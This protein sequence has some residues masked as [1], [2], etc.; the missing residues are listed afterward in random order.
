MG[1]P[2]HL[3]LQSRIIFTPDTVQANVAKSEKG[4]RVGEE[5]GGKPLSVR[6][7]Y[8]G[9]LEKELGIDSQEASSL[10]ILFLNLS[11]LADAVNGHKWREAPC[12][13]GPYRR[14]PLMFSG[15]FTK[16]TKCTVE[17][18]GGPGQQPTGTSSPTEEGMNSP[19]FSFQS[20]PGGGLDGQ[21][22]LAIS[23]PPR[24]FFPLVRLCNS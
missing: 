22:T 19:V 1:S 20:W 12:Q 15:E 5:K 17:E 2:P 8:E 11:V 4:Q 7:P 21:R 3:A 10:R 14:K 6:L 13:A 18:N 24:L 9:A 16:Q 23:P